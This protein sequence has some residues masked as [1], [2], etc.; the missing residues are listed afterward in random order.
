[1]V[2]Q[3]GLGLYA[4][5]STAGRQVS[6]S[7]GARNKSR[8]ATESKMRW[9]AGGMVEVARVECVVRFAEGVAEYST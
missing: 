4:S 7:A 1:M 2:Q 9:R 5:R 3:A 6:A 8:R